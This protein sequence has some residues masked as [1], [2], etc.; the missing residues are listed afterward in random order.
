MAQKN[1]IFLRAA[2]AI[3]FLGMASLSPTSEPTK[4]PQNHPVRNPTWQEI[5]QALPLFVRFPSLAKNTA[6]TPLG[7]LPTPLESLPS[8]AKMLQL[9]SLLIKR[10][11]LSGELF[12]GNKVRKLEFLLSEATKQGAERVVTWGAPGSSHTTA[13]AIYS[14]NLGL[15]CTCMYLP[16]PK[17][18]ANEH[19]LQLTKKH[20]ATQETYRGHGERELA[21]YKKNK[22]HR[23]A[24]GKSMYFIPEGAS[25]V[26]GA[27]GFVNAA[28]EMVAQCKD[29]Q[30]PLPDTIYLLTGSSGSVAGFLVGLDLMAITTTPVIVALGP[31]AYPNQ[32]RDKIE[33]LY[34][35]IMQYMTHLDLGMRTYR[36]PQNTV[37]YRHGFTE[38]SHQELTTAAPLTQKTINALTGYSLDPVYATRLWTA[39]LLDCQDGN[40]PGKRVMLWNTGQLTK[41]EP[42]GN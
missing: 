4:I 31:D 34:A 36:A 7:L 20:F 2:L 32:Q 13:T 35:A 14:Y 29:L 12:G 24:T 33:K 6:Y 37:L 16:I 5:K 28:C 25:D 15:S 9:E 42:V 40:S 39:F 21:L 8:A 22:E 3:I 1:P 41:S 30:E 17:Q 26:L 10:D 11:D 38:A 18:P 23:E 19:N 27:L